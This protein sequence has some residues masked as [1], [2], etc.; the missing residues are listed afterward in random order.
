MKKIIIP[1]LVIIFLSDCATPPRQIQESQQTEIPKQETFEGWYKIGQEL[2][3]RGKY[4]EAGKAFDKAVKLDPNLYGIWDAKGKELFLADKYDQIIVFFGRII[5]SRPED[6]YYWYH[7]LRAYSLK[8]DKQNTFKE[9][10]RLIA[11]DTIYKEYAKCEPEFVWLRD[12]EEFKKITYQ[13]TAEDWY[14]KA[15]YW[16]GF[17]GRDTP[18]QDVWEISLNK[19]VEI[20]TQNPDTWYNFGSLLCD[21]GKYDRAIEIL[22]KAI[23][24]DPKHIK[25]WKIRGSCLSNIGKYEEA[26]EAHDKAIEYICPDL[27]ISGVSER[28]FSGDVWWAKGLIL[29][30]LE[31]YDDAINAYTKAI[32]SNPRPYIWYPLSRLYALR[33]DR[34]NALRNLAIAIHWNYHYNYDFTKKKDRISGRNEFQGTDNHKAESRK[35]DAFKWLWDDEDFKTLTNQNSETPKFQTAQ[36]GNKI[37]QELYNQGRYDE[38][39]DVFDKVIE[40]DPRNKEAWFQIGNTLMELKEVPRWAVTAYE[41]VLKIDPNHKD[42]LKNK[43]IAFHKARKFKEAIAAYDE[44]LKTESKNEEIL[45]KKAIALWRLK[46]Y[47]KAI[48]ALEEVLKIDENI[49]TS[50]YLKACCYVLV[51]E[52]NKALADLERAFRLNSSWQ[53]Y[54]SRDEQLQSL[55]EDGDFKKLTDSR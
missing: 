31:R 21:R 18:G 40:L 4:E 52:K 55:W 5:A 8:K 43:G 44:F 54:A 46:E 41:E 36:K 22:D 16:N 29:N 20:G 6:L 24:L 42:A 27:D 28:P 26:I 11:I 49:A 9:L 30:K 37:G 7:R 13:K 45:Q 51:G 53:K 48:P 39:L 50:W 1:L 14:G 23:A 15:K 17:P 34:E 2:C 3:E 47:K 19:A 12:D 38:A 25:A 32:E 10:A 35:D 33:H